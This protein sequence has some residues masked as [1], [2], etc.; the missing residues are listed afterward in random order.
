[1]LRYNARMLNDTRIRQT[2]PADKPIKLA[3][4]H[5]LYL[6]IRPTGAKLWRYRYRI[7]GKENVFA[8]G[9]Y[10]AVSLADARQA[11]DAARQ[12]VQSGQHPAAA[13]K[14]ERLQRIA[15]QANT[16]EAVAKEWIDKKRAHWSPYY[17]HQ[18]ERFLE[19]D[20][21]PKLGKRPIREIRPADLLT[22]LQRVEKRAPTVALNLRQWSSA[23]FRYAVATLRADADP[24]A[25]L[26]G[27]IHRLPVQ[28]ARAMD[29]AGLRELKRRLVLFKGYRQTGIAIELLLLTMLRTIELRR[30]T[31]DEI[32][33][34]AGEW[35]IPAEKMK[36]RRPHIV[37][38]SHQALE[39]LRELQRITGAG[40][41]LFPNTRRPTTIMSG[42]TVNRALEYMGWEHSGHDFRATAST[43][44]RELGWRDD[45]IEMQLAHAER[46]KTR[47]AYNHWQYL[48][49]RRA[50]LQAWADYWG[51]L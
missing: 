45:L 1:M 43:R 9:A 20:L 44:L 41:Y 15:E 5:G 29:A 21:F 4:S 6:E 49:E 23:I 47:A 10:P 42:T 22:E 32:D 24:A 36:M 13:R 38:L 16:F 17:L 31:W 48:P 12:L 8:I 11:R 37:P 7:D 40:E 50:M 46:S 51:G 35:R 30:G 34:H 14:Q 27:A 26:R 2:K 25:P 28:H 18:V 19:L 39:L 33:W 3:D